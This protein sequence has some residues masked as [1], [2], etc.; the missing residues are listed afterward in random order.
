[1]SLEQKQ[2]SKTFTL[3]DINSSEYLRKNGIL[4]GDLFEDGK[5][6]RGRSSDMLGIKQIT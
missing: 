5:M 3:E 6:T 1:M 4:A 2:E